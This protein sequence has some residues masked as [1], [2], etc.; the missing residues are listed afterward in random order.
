MLDEGEKEGTSYE[1]E[2]KAARSNLDNSRGKLNYS[3]TN[4]ITRHQRNFG[5]EYYWTEQ[6]VLS[7]DP[8]KS[9]LE[10][11]ATDCKNKNQLDQVKHSSKTSF[12]V[13]RNVSVLEKSGRTYKKNNRKSDTVGIPLVPDEDHNDGHSSGRDSI[14]EISDNVGD[15]CSQAATIAFSPPP[16]TPSKCFPRNFKGKNKYLQY[17]RKCFK[18]KDSVSSK[19]NLS[20]IKK[21]TFLDSSGMSNK[22]FVVNKPGLIEGIQPQPDFQFISDELNFL[23]S[24]SGK[25]ATQLHKSDKQKRLE[26]KRKGS[27]IRSILRKNFGAKRSKKCE[28]TTANPPPEKSDSESSEFDLEIDSSSDF[29]FEMDRRL[30]ENAR[31]NNLSVMNVK[32]ILHTVIT[33]EHVVAMMNNTLKSAGEVDGEFIEAVYEPKMTRSKIKEV[34]EKS[35]GMTPWPLPSNKS[36]S[37]VSI[38]DIPFNEDEDD[39]DYNPEKDITAEIESDDE[40]ES[41][42]SSLTCSPN[43]QPVRSSLMPLRPSCKQSLPD[44][45]D[46]DKKEDMTEETIARRTRSKLPLHDTSL[47]ELE[48]HFMAPDITEDM[49][50]TECND[51]DWKDFLKS[52]TKGQDVEDPSEALDDDANDPEYNY[53][54]EAENELPDDEDFRDDRLVRVSKKELHG[55]L[56]ELFNEDANE[57]EDT[58]SQP[59]ITT[60]VDICEFGR[61]SSFDITVTPEQSLIIAAQVKQHTQLLC[62]LTLLTHGQQDYV[63]ENSQCINFLQELQMFG[64]QSPAREKSVFRASNLEGSFKVIQEFKPA[65]AKKNIYKTLSEDLKKLILK[66]PEIFPYSPLLPTCGSIPRMKLGN[67]K[68]SFTP[69]QDNL[70][71]LGFE[72]FGHMRSFKRCMY[73]RQFMLPCRTEKQIRARLKNLRSKRALD[74]P[75]KYVAQNMKFPVDFPTATLIQV[76]GL[77]CSQGTNLHPDSPNWYKLMLDPPPPSK[78]ST[79]PKRKSKKTS[80][81]QK[82]EEGE[83][84]IGSHLHYHHE[85]QQALNESLSSSTTLVSTDGHDILQKSHVTPTEVRLS[86]FRP[87]QLTCSTTIPSPMATQH[88][89]FSPN[90]H[91]SGSA[92]NVSNSS[93]I[94]VIATMA[95]QL[96]SNS[97]NPIVSAKNPAFISHAIAKQKELQKTPT[98]NLF[99]VYESL[100]SKRHTPSSKSAVFKHL[101]PKPQ[102]ISPSGCRQVSLCLEKKRNSPRRQKLQQKAR[103]ICPKGVL[104]KPHFSPTS[105]AAYGLR[106]R[107]KRSPRMTTRGS[108]PQTILPKNVNQS[109]G[110]DSACCNLNTKRLKEVSPASGG[111]SANFVTK[112]LTNAGASM[113]KEDWLASKTADKVPVAS[114]S[115]LTTAHNEETDAALASTAS[116]GITSGGCCHSEKEN[117]QMGNGDSH[118]ADLMAASSTIGCHLKRSKDTRTKAQKRN[119]IKLAM[120]APNLIEKDPRRDH[121]DTIF[122]LA[123]LNKVKETL[124]S[125]LERYEQFLRILFEFG[126]SEHSPVVL[127]KDLSCLLKDYP[128]LVHHFAAFLSPEHALLCGCYKTTVDFLR[129]RNFL[130]KIEIIFEKHPSQYQKVLKIFA[131]WHRK[132]TH[133]EEELYEMLLPMFKGQDELLTEF[134]G[135]FGFQPPPESCPEDFEEVTLDGGES[136]MENKLMGYENVELPDTANPYGM[137]GCPC[138]CHKDKEKL[139]TEGLNKKKT[140]SK[141]MSHCAMCGLTVKDGKLY[142]KTTGKLKHVRARISEPFDVS[143]YDT[144]PAESNMEEPFVVL[145]KARVAVETVSSS[146]TSES[147]LTSPTSS[148]L[149]TDKHSLNKGTSSGSKVL[150]AT[151]INNTSKTHS[152]NL[153][154]SGENDKNRAKVNRECVSKLV[155]PNNGTTKVSAPATN[156]ILAKAWEQACQQGP[157]EVEDSLHDLLNIPGSHNQSKTVVC[158]VGPSMPT[159][160]LLPSH[161]SQSTI[162]AVIT[163]TPT[164]PLVPVT[165]LTMLPLST[166][167]IQQQPQ[168]NQ[169]SLPAFSHHFIPNVTD[170]NDTPLSK[171]KHRQL[172]SKGDKRGVID[173]LLNSAV[174]SKKHLQVI[175]PNSINYTH[176]QQAVSNQLYSEGS[177]ISTRWTKWMDKLILDLVRKEGASSQVFEKISY[178]INGRTP[179]QIKERYS[180]LLSLFRQMKR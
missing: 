110:V 167:S 42:H 41:I 21:P 5:E 103:L 166:I 82:Q 94:D 58:T 49:Y 63:E 104:I 75:V 32:S 78:K 26:R 36:E 15:T 100:Q 127:Y 120:L 102:Q 141:R 175:T 29:E 47:T 35:D 95:S 27:F 97:T 33:N 59:S 72:Q 134:S 177:N 126:K 113:Q 109:V 168:L 96:L 90:K 180:E 132:V 69:A 34:L 98:K 139:P 71:A 170:H 159:D 156:D 19:P 68:S 145:E 150:S 62:Q 172:L 73:I 9:S 136:E 65:A 164:K 119:D 80:N 178:Q 165:S 140:K 84:L 171:S 39:D 125:D 169:L 129:A 91:R 53:L 176:H 101:A 77:L 64:K 118:I 137:P 8:D 105:M 92:D 54:A 158:S 81:S 155:D 108:E 38:L 154:K 142:F 14:I 67:L 114:S 51:N 17:Q 161:P 25:L 7:K 87:G 160:F 74:N 144:T 106:K 85:Q 107:A 23:N 147:L 138:Q 4:E 43:L 2:T 121:R 16:R 52:L 86:D 18:T 24:E 1:C 13:T 57:E 22:H 148:G 128:E 40:T 162:S 37:K 10:E 123:Y 112:G 60:G 124:K 30:E 163:S 99:P 115:T 173:N 79:P 111:Q 116:G 131:E 152:S 12:L 55:L 70:L 143:D 88:K 179:K 146:V 93:S 48:A 83:E 31:K 133:R 46:D 61:R 45:D 66:K 3:K 28:R 174:L 122:A 151:G 135:L 56:D 76:E 89:T 50:D 117:C 6:K 20:V 44:T 153:P 149:A 11:I 157:A 130:R